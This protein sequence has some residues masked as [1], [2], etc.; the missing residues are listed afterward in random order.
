MDIFLGS[1]RVN[2]VRIVDD[3]KFQFDLVVVLRCKKKVGN[4][5]IVDV[6]ALLEDFQGQSITRE[7]EGGEA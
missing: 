1:D 3:I 2:I 6:K 4:T 7:S 5:R